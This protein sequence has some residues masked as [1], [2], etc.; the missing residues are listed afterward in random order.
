MDLLGSYQES[1]KRNAGAKYTHYP[2]HVNRNCMVADNFILKRAEKPFF[3]LY[4]NSDTLGSVPSILI[5]RCI[6]ER[7]VDIDCNST[8][9]LL[10]KDLP[11]SEV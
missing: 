2:E 11:P 8:G 6:E 9:I 5:L 3:Y 4:L 10:N 1:Y 7:R